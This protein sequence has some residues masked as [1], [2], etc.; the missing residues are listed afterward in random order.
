MCIHCRAAE[1]NLSSLIIQHLTLRALCFPLLHFYRW[2]QEWSREQGM[3]GYDGDVSDS[4]F[5]STGSNLHYLW[6]K[7][8]AASTRQKGHRVSTLTA[9]NPTP[10]ACLCK[11][12]QIIIPKHPFNSDS[13]WK[14]KVRCSKLAPDGKIH[15]SEKRSWC[16]KWSNKT[17]LTVNLCSAGLRRWKGGSV[18]LCHSLTF[19]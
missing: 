9:H 11:N 12:T 16:Q 17:K 13:D 14:L 15:P 6:G 4:C 8:D 10:P 5:P 3:M 1:G 19:S 2:S 18:H 7:R